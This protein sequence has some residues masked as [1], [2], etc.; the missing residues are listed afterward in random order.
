MFCNLGPN[1]IGE[2]TFNRFLINIQQPFKKGIRKS[3]QTKQTRHET[4]SNVPSSSAIVL[5]GGYYAQVCRVSVSKNIKK[6]GN[7][8]PFPGIYI[9]VGHPKPV[10]VIECLPYQQRHGR[11][12]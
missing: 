1:H 9:Y 3:Y 7:L 12:R 4:Q 8:L 11:L 6:T 2:Y 5:F 10:Q